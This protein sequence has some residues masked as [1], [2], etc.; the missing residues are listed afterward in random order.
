[1]NTNYS[2]EI[3]ILATCLYQED[4]WKEPFKLDESVFTHPFNKRLAGTI[5]RHIDENRSVGVLMYTLQDKVEGT[6][7]ESNFLD[8]ISANVLALSTMKKYVEEL[9]IMKIARKY[10]DPR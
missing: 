2:I 6:K 4:F 8:V 10:N 9:R 1:M 5:N 3:S 7:Y